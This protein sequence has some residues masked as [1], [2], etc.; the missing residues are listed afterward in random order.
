MD[1]FSPATSYFVWVILTILLI[2]LWIVTLT[3]ILKNNF[4]GPNNKLVWT[5]VV[6]LVPFVGV[7]LYY[8]V[9]R[10]QKI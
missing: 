6:I 10:S 1:L 8:L 3:D 4:R 5:T 7:I 2:V 9:G